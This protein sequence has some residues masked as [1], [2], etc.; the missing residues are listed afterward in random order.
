MVEF[1]Y[2]EDIYNC[3]QYVEKIFSVPESDNIFFAK[4]NMQFFPPEDREKL[5]SRN[6]S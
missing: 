4:I 1:D 5:H 2:E 6:I 3:E